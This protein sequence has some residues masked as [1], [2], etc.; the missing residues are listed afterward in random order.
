MSTLME[1]N[2]DD[3][4]QDSYPSQ[5]YIELMFICNRFVYY[6]EISVISDMFKLVTSLTDVVSNDFDL[7]I[8]ISEISYEQC[9]NMGSSK[10]FAGLLIFYLCISLY[11]D[12]KNEINTDGWDKLEKHNIKNVLCNYSDDALIKLKP[13]IKGY[14]SRLDIINKRYDEMIVSR[15]SVMKRSD[16]KG[17]LS[18]CAEEFTE[19]YVLTY[20]NLINGYTC[21]KLDEL[22][23]WISHYGLKIPY[24]QNCRLNDNDV[25]YLLTYTNKH[26]D[27]FNR[28]LYKILYPDIN[29][30]LDVLYKNEPNVVINFFKDLFYLGM[31]FRRWL[32]PGNPYP[33][34]ESETN[35]NSRKFVRHVSRDLYYQLVDIYSSVTDSKLLHYY[36]IE[37][38]VR[39][40]V[41]HLY[42]IIKLYP[43]LGKVLYDDYV[44]VT[45]ES[46]LIGIVNLE[47]CIRIASTPLIKTAWYVL[48]T[49]NNTSVLDPT[50]TDNDLLTLQKIGNTPRGEIE[51]V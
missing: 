17:N 30:T 49:Y 33:L 14:K 47:I 18:L 12:C 41:G 19:E 9:I 20:G 11:S 32:G 46:I 1:G 43:I 16:T 50:F 26:D 36:F 5:L 37:S 13:E 38:F 48:K 31:Y 39:S 15:F 6:L 21:I 51:F 40:K 10:D 8:I 4:D 45:I 7:N 34:V 35:M 2:D 24:D 44:D 3:L 25:K 42:D 27:E 23:Q 28:L 29:K 22:K